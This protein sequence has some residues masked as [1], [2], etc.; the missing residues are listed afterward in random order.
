MK[1]TRKTV[2]ENWFNAVK[3]SPASFAV[4]VVD[5]MPLWSC[6]PTARAPVDAQVLDA[7]LLA[8]FQE[9]IDRFLRSHLMQLI[10]R[11]ASLPTS[12]LGFKMRARVKM[13]NMRVADSYPAA[14]GITLPAEC[15]AFVNYLFP[16]EDD[17]K[18]WDDRIHKW[19]ESLDLD[20]ETEV[21]ESY[22]Q[23]TPRPLPSSAQ[24]PEDY[25]TQRLTLPHKAPA[26]ALPPMDEDDLAEFIQATKRRRTSS[27]RSPVPTQ[28]PPAPENS[29]VLTEDGNFADGHGTNY[30]PKDDRVLLDRYCRQ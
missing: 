1:K 18:G 13:H 30:V 9:Q 23:Y 24:D 4:P 3:A 22:L 8:P 16:F 29:F 11:S 28:V 17:D 27:G 14:L 10:Y 19:Y 26:A 2:I 25:V 7:A 21:P 20:S 5:A 12:T 15:Q 6:F